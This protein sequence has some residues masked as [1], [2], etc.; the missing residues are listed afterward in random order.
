MK[1]PLPDRQLQTSCK[2]CKFATYDNNTQV[3]CVAGRIDKFNDLVIPAYDDEQEFYVIDTFCN[4]YRT[5]SWNVDNVDNL[6]KV[7]EEAGI[8]CDIIIKCDHMTEDYKNHV[9]SWIHSLKKCYFTPNKLKITLYNTTSE[10]NTEELKH[11]MIAVHSSDQMTFMSTCINDSFHLHELAMYS[12][13]MY[14]MLITQDNIPDYNIVNVL[15]SAINE[16]LKKCVVAHRNGL[17]IISNVAYRLEYEQSQKLDYRH[18]VSQ[19][20]EQSKGV[21]LYLDI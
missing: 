4:F 15:N 19:L 17:N 21:N 8:S 6:L 20:I 10:D 16:D 18:N 13:F 12:P 14:N 2:K 1:F 3:G 9:I 11:R 7:K 5:Q